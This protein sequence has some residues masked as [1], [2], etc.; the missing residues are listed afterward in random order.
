M[1]FDSLRRALDLGQTLGQ[2]TKRVLVV[3]ARRVVKGTEIDERIRLA[4]DLFLQLPARARDR[5]LARHVELSGRHLENRTGDRRPE[6]TH[7]YDAPVLIERD[8]TDGS[9]VTDDLALKGLSVRVDELAVDETQKRR[10]QQ[11]A[12]ANLAETRVRRR[13]RVRSRTGAGCA[14]LPCRPQ[15]R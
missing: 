7:H 9:G 5:L 3:E 11:L 10:R 2:V 1:L 8:D 12:F 13:H 4:P 6:L 14:P 15:R